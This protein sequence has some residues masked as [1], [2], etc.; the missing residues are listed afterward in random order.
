ML[1]HDYGLLSYKA[2]LSQLMMLYN[3]KALPLSRQGFLL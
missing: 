3:L 2:S 1:T